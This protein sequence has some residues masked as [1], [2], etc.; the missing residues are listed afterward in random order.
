VEEG[1]KFWKCTRR[2]W[3][4]LIEEG[5]NE[6]FELKHIP[7][8]EKRFSETHALPALTRLWTREKIQQPEQEV[9]SLE[10]PQ[11]LLEDVLHNSIEVSNTP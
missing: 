7:I 9:G 1:N 10:E 5:L 3:F 6:N 2:E 8:I 11:K 4:C